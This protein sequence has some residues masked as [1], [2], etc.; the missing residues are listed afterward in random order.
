MRASVFTECRAFWREA[1]PEALKPVGETTFTAGVAAQ[2]E[3]GVYGPARPCAGIVGH[4]DLTLGDAVAE[5]LEAHVA[6]GGGRF[7]GVRHSGSWDAD[8]AVLG[9]L[10][11]NPPGLYA[12]AAFREGFARLADHALSFDAWILE[13][14]LPDL[15]DLA[16][17]FPDQPIVLDHLA[18]P[19]NL[20]AYAGRLP[21]RFDVW[22][23][24]LRE[25]AT[26]PNVTVK[27]GGLAM[28]FFEPTP[29]TVSEPPLSATLARAW[30]PYVETA[31]E[32]FGVD[33]CMFESNFP[34][35][36][37]TCDYRTLWNALKRTVRGASEAEKAA[38]FFGTAKRVYRLDV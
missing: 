33:R 34:V 21:D 10:S 8:P 30:A 24:N 18:T 29:P 15:I 6:A 35:D 19:L 5:V 28:C 14:Q 38:L 13:P 22:R 7:K 31:I 1:G 36:R 20:G 9:P 23:A 27:L 17:A 26:L 16:R 3:S 11:R 2:A 4:A 32:A 37:Y 12:G 25:L